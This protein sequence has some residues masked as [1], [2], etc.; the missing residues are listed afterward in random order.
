M[1]NNPAL[2]KKKKPDKNGN[3]FPMIVYSNY[4]VY[5]LKYL[6]VLFEQENNINAI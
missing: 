4:Y 1:G 2:L 3:F 6:D 5:F